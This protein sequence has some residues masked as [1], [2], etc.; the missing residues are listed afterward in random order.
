MQH[1]E[2]VRKQVAILQRAAE[3]PAITA[4]SL[5]L[6]HIQ[7]HARHT[8]VH[9]LRVWPLLHQGTLQNSQMA[10]SD[11]TSV[12]RQQSFCQGCVQDAK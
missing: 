4:R 2:G 7:Y 11:I 12:C 1:L 3:P 9:F 10:S 8:D 5:P 6:P